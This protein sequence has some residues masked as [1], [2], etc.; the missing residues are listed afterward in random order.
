MVHT[1]YI[2]HLIA[3]TNIE[4]QQQ[5]EEINPNLPIV[6]CKLSGWSP[7]STCSALC[8]SGKRTRSRHIIQMPQNGGKACD[9]KLTRTQS[10][11]NLPPCP[12]STSNYHYHQQHHHQ[13]QQ[14]SIGSH[15][16]NRAPQSQNRGERKNHTN[17]RHQANKNTQTPTSITV[18]TT[19]TTTTTAS[20]SMMDDEDDSKFSRLLLSESQQTSFPYASPF[21]DSYSIGS[22]SLADQQPKLMKLL[23]GTSFHI[24]NGHLY[25]ISSDYNSN[26]NNNSNTMT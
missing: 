21:N 26:I 15:S 8:G 22:S 5:K 4:N 2:I 12:P 13:Q 3:T 25:L 18:T 7:W 16:Q 1:S 11:K 9:R 20:S 10:C 14:Q 17:N 6:D 24:K 23:G 19:T